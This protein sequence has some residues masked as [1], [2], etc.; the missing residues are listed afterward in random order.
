MGSSMRAA[1]R[2]RTGPIAD[3]RLCELASL[4]IVLELPF[5]GGGDLTADDVQARLLVL[6]YRA[7]IDVDRA[8]VT[9]VTVGQTANHLLPV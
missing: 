7:P 4:D 3:Q 8:G 1:S 6:D 9:H 2:R 5:E